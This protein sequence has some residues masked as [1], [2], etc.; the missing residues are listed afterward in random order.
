MTTPIQATFDLIRSL[1][2]SSEIKV[3]RRFEG[4]FVD[5]LIQASTEPDLVAF[6]ERLAATLDTSVEYV[7]GKR[8]SAFMAAAA[9][10]EAPGILAFIRQRPRIAAMV[11]LLR[12]QS[13]REEA[14]AS[15]RLPDL[16]ADTGH[17]PVA[18]EYQVP[19]T[20]ACL[21][22]LA[23]GGDAKAGNATL[24]R[25]CQVLSTTGAVLDLPFYAG[26]AWRGQMRD[27]LADHFLESIGLA[28]SRSNPPVALWFFHALYAGGVLEEGGEAMKAVKARLGNHGAMKIDGVSELRQ[29][30][31][32]LS[33]LGVAVGNRVISGR[34]NVGDLRP[35]CRE[36]GTG[37]IPAAELMTWEFLTRREDHEG[38]GDDDGH[39]GMIATTE[40]LRAG[41]VL[42]GGLD[43][44]PHISDLE[45]AALG[46]AVE[47]LMHRGTLGA[48]TRRG[49][50]QVSID[51]HRLPDSAPYDQYLAD[52]REAILDYLRDL[53]ALTDAH[54]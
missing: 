27:L 10:P 53:G 3:N 28:P 22:A 35:Q 24:F 43:M 52:N 18:P 45:R 49:L 9:S 5:R 41:T 36:W 54:D 12:D 8:M 48:E 37:D 44:H 4:F 38:R 26:N 17:A 42:D 19:V 34:I 20:A 15:I 14:I 16:D 33:L 30:L 50:G 40:C 31:P 47:L 13:D 2:N 1:A 46:K 7:G 23:H 11:C 51:A 29:M 39:H 6:A 21:S 32:G 25:R